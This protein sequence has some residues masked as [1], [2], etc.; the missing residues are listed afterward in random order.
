MSGNG[1]EDDTDPLS[2]SHTLRIQAISHLSDI[3]SVKIL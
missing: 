1:E 2:L 3:V